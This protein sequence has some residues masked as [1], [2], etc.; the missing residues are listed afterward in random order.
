VF[1]KDGAMPRRPALFTQADLAR[2]LRAFR[3]V[4]GVQGKIELR[5]DGTIEIVA[6]GQSA[7]PPKVEIARK[8]EIVL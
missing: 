3:Q 8:S 1:I 2:A 4:N 5:P 7:E 6:A